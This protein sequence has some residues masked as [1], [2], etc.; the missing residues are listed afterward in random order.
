M[1]IFISHAAKDRQ[2]ASSLA[3]QL[4][5]ADFRVW[6]AAEDVGPGDNWAKKIGQALDE[7]DVMI[8]LITPGS[9]E[10]EALRGDIQYALT[11]KK[12]EQRL[13]PV[14]VGF[15]TF[16]AGKD[17]PW[18]LLKMD[19]VY[20]ES[21][22][23]G[24]EQVIGRVKAVIGREAPGSKCSQLRFSSRIPATI[25]RWRSAWP[26]LRAHGVPVWFSASNI[27]GAQQWHD[28]IGAALARCDWY[29]VLLSPDAVD[30]KWVKR[31]LFYALE[32]DAYNNRII[33]VRY[34]DCDYKRLSWTLS[35]LQM[36]DLSGD[37]AAGFRELLR[38]WGIGLREDLLA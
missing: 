24:F 19:P 12:F 10:S 38:I 33:P 36:V 29:I 14:L 5:R 9:L 8:A 35:A 16:A 30:S 18:I 20:V 2:L 34:R 15:A 32:N 31:E 25:M 26:A 7:S 6:Y 22:A 21:P 3:M 37:F 11:E 23:G 13:I 17:V 4:A 27:L 28:E 1:Q